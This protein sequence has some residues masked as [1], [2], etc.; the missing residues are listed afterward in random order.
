MPYCRSLP[1]TSTIKKGQPNMKGLPEDVLT[2]LEEIIDGYL[3][4][5]R[6]EHFAE[7]A[8]TKATFLLEYRGLL[9]H[10]RQNKSLR[11]SFGSFHC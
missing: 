2:F 10:Y 5:S 3:V 7:W 4:G 1:I 9:N 11:R 6:D 8:A